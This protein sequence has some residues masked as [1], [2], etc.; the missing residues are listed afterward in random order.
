MSSSQSH[1]HDTQVQ[2]KEKEIQDV[3]QKVD[4][5]KQRITAT[6]KSL[7]IL[8]WELKDATSQLEKL[9]KD[10][11]MEKKEEMFFHIL[12]SLNILLRYKYINHYIMIVKLLTIHLNVHNF[13]FF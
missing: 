6:E 7:M 5:L 12:I 2:E 11:N 4:S 10:V 1:Q 8:K 9:N 3:K 13:S